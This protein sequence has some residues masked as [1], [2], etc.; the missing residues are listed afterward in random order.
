MVAKVTRLWG[1]HPRTGKPLWPHDHW[2]GERKLPQRTQKLG[3]EC[4]DAYVQAYPTLC[5]LVP[6][7][8]SAEVRDALSDFVWLEKQM[9]FGYFYTF[10]HAGPQPF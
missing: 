8:P 1:T 10:L 9:G 7:G 4:E 2:S 3:L 6:P 5:G